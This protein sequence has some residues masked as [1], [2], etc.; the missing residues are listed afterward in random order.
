[1]EVVCIISYKFNKF[2]DKAISSPEIVRDVLS[3]SRLTYLRNRRTLLALRTSSSVDAEV[4]VGSNINS[5]VNAT[6]MTEE[7]ISLEISSM[8]KEPVGLFYG[9]LI[10]LNVGLILDISTEVPGI[11][12][13]PKMLL[14]SNSKSEV[15]VEFLASRNCPNPQVHA[16]FAKVLYYCAVENME[17]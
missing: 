12:Y 17:C 3:F 8:T 13:V 4:L 5:L 9:D 6:Y 10:L 16:T 2:D 15:D 1:M 14:L 7:C 11:T